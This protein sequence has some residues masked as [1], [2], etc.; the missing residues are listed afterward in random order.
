M[1]FQSLR[2]FGAAAVAVTKQAAVAVADVTV[3]TYNDLQAVP[4]TIKCAGP[5]CVLQVAVPPNIFGNY[6]YHIPYHTIISSFYTI[7]ASCVM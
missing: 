4:D 5:N 1:A 7:M 2:S 6:L 3:K